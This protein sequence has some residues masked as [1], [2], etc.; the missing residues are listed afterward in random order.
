MDTVKNVVTLHL[1]QLFYNSISSIYFF[2]LIGVLGSDSS[3]DVTTHLVNAAAP[4]T[5]PPPAPKNAARM[6]ALALAESAQEV[7]IH[8]QSSE[9]CTQESTPSSQDVSHFQDSSQA[10]IVTVS[11]EEPITGSSL[12]PSQNIPTSTV[13]S[14]S[15]CPIT[16]STTIKQHLLDLSTSIVKISEDTIC[17]TQTDPDS[18]LSDPPQCPG[19]PILP[20]PARKETEDQQTFIGQIPV[21]T[22]SSDNTP[23]SNPSGSCRDGGVLS[24]PE[25]SLISY[26]EVNVKAEYPAAKHTPTGSIPEFAYFTV[27]DVVLV[28]VILR[29]LRVCCIN[30]AKQL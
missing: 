15:L 4:S 28:M 27:R 1:S 10:P 22:N 21:H 3:Q 12:P 13:T 11:V 14:A 25:A 20:S 26:L 24:Q 17:S 9:P 30:T 6:L 29:V 19:S 16:S 7:S 18:T 2:S 5:A 8:S 23:A